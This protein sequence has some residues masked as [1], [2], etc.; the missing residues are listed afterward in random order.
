[1][2]LHDDTNR[3]DLPVAVIGAGPVGLAAAARLA[4][5]KLPF[6][7]LEAGDRPAASIRRWGHVRLFSPWR[8]LVDDAA[9]SLLASTGWTAPPADG[10][11][12]GQGLIDAYLTPLGEHPTIAAGLRTGVGVVNITRAG[13][14][15]LSDRGREDRPFALH[16]LRRDGGREVILARAVI[17]ASGTYGHPNPLGTSGV[18][19]PGELKNAD[20]LYYGIPH[21][22]G[23]D[24]ER[25]A[26]ARVGVVGSGHSAFNALLDLAS[27]PEAE[28][29]HVSWFIRSETGPALFGGEDDD[30][31]SERGALGRRM[32]LL[33][34]SGKLTLHT[35]FRTAAVHGAA[36][37]GPITLESEDGQRSGPLDIVVVV[38]GFRPDLSMTRELRVSLDP[39]V[40]AP[41][42]LAPLI[43]PNLHSCGTVPPHGFRELSHPDEG[44]Y[45]VGMKSYGRAPTFLLLTGY[46]QVRSVV[47]AIAGDI[48]AA[49]RVELVLPETGVCSTDLITG[50]ASSCCSPSA[51][52]P[53][54]TVQAEPAPAEDACCAPTEAGEAC[55]E[56]GS[57]PVSIGSARSAR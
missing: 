26:G 55:W 21:V 11:P 40:E 32:R 14:D 8:Y 34:E 51:P 52:P 4:E 10:I 5:E 27:L 19:A 36:G 42:A 29:P 1:M 16:A 17:D 18:P 41:A 54:S 15:K 13:I 46:E 53:P 28:R 39:A 23:R 33:A 12:T 25:F 31:L 20:R 48:E 3:S 43:D 50:S 9:R 38:T 6:V 56:P 44:Y 57:V 35:N 2:Q 47:K 7:L 22:R 37:R 49:D 24:R 45:T 30:E